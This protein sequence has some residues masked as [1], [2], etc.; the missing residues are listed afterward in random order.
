MNGFKRSSSR[1]RSAPP[2]LELLEDRVVPS[3]TPVDLTTVGASE[4]VGDAVFVQSTIRPAGSGQL[5]S[6]L[7]I[8][9]HGRGGVEQG[10]NT[11]ARPVEFDEK[12]G[13]KYTR[14]LEL[15]KVGTV[16]VGGTLYREFLLDVNEPGARTKSLISLDELKLYLSDDGALTG[17]D[18]ESGKLADLDPIFDLD[19]AEDTCVILNAKLSSGS[20][21]ADALVYIKD[22]LFSTGTDSSK[23]YLYSKFGETEA[24]EG[25]FEEWAARERPF[26]KGLG[27]ISGTVFEDGD[28][29]GT[30]GANEVGFQ[31]WTV[32]LDANENGVQDDGEASTTTD[33]EGRYRFDKLATGLG[34]FSTYTVRAVIEE[35]YEAT[36]D[37]PAAIELDT[38]GEAVTDVN[39]GN[40]L[41]APEE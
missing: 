8:Q 35:G 20:G 26:T 6:F 34:E 30:Q 33:S 15:S 32:Y 3:G 7:R 36:T 2:L 24:A 31:G 28:R 23:V 18:E 11:D 29:D 19:A 16:N 21:G 13:H 40:V 25:G 4:E 22:S 5:K 12:R 9:G 17:Y 14:S 39:F 38:A 41:I 1:R 27:S 37:P 10:Y